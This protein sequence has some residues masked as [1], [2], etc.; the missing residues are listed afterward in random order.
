MHCENKVLNC[1]A[2][3][4]RSR[5]VQWSFALEQALNLYFHCL[6]LVYKL[7]LLNLRN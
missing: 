3:K 7:S 4:G 5:Q 1:F 2:I 6:I